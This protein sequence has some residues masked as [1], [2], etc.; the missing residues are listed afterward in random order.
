MIIIV[1]GEPDVHGVAQHTKREG[2]VYVHLLALRVHKCLSRMLCICVVL[3]VEVRKRVY[4]K[5][6][7]RKLM[8]VKAR[9]R[10]GTANMKRFAGLSLIPASHFVVQC[11]PIVGILDVIAITTMHSTVH[12]HM[13]TQALAWHGPW[14]YMACQRGHIQHICITWIGRTLSV[15]WT[16]DQLI[17]RS[18]HVFP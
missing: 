6:L 15:G 13:C 8:C 11:F 18:M 17:S 3:Y 16:V 7:A 10:H 1:G 5:W 12:H 4:V 9:H 2:G 14:P